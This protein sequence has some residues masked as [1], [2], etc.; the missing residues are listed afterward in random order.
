MVLLNTEYASTFGDG[1]SFRNDTLAEA[2][3]NGFR[4]HW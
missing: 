1:R 3:L 4:E 2:L